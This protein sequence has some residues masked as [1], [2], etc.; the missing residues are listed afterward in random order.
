MKFQAARDTALTLQRA[1]LTDPPRVPGAE[2]AAHYQPASTDAEIGGDW[3]DAVLLPHGPLILAIGDVIGH[4]LDAATAMSQLRSMLRVIVYDP[5]A[6]RSPAESLTRL[7]RVAEGLGIASMVTVALATM[8]PRQSG[9]WRATLS[10][11]GHPPPLLLPASG[12]ARFLYAGDGPDTPLCVAPELPRVTWQQDLAVGDTLL[13]YTD[14]LVEVPGADL[15]HGLAGLAAQAT[16][17]RER[18]R[19]VAEL[20]AGLLASARGTRDDIAIIGFRAATP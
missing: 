2:L 11:A 17:L 4:D 3:Y 5:A 13:L 14:G 20:T 15:S 8:E 18:H 6:A 10:N 19:S 16:A 1:L 9:G 7:D 12:P